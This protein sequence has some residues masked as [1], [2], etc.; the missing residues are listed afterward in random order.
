MIHFIFNKETPQYMY[1]KGDQTGDQNILTAF[2]QHCNLVDPI[3]YLPQWRGRPKFTQDFVFRY[4]QQSGGV[5]Y[6]CSIGLWQEAYI[7]FKKNNAEFTGLFENQDMIKTDV[8]ISLDDFK[9]TVDSWGLAFKPRDYQYA[10]SYKILQYRSSVSELA[11]RAGKTLIA[12]MVFRYAMERMNVRKILMIVPSIQLVK[13]AYNDFNEYKEFFKTECL[14]AGGSEVQSAN[15]TV[16]TFQSLIKYLD[17]KSKKFNPSFFDGYDC[18]FVDETH[19]ATAT[20]IKT[21]ISQP[22]IK[23]VKLKFGMTGTLPKNDTIPH[24]AL[25]ALLGAKIQQIK[26]AEL[27]E[28]GYISPVSIHQIRFHYSDEEC[29]KIFIK[30]GEYA[31]GNYITEKRNGKQCK[32]KLEQPENQIIYKKKLPYVLQE[33]KTAQSYTNDGYIELLRSIITESDSANL[34]VVERMMTHFMNGRIDYLCKNIL[35]NCP[36]NTLILAHHTEYI[37]KISKIISKKYPDRPVMVI[38]GS[39]TAKKRLEI[40][41]KLKER[42]DCILIASFGTMSTGITLPNLCHGI[43]F[44]SFKSNVVNMQSIGRGLGLSDMKDKYELYDCIDCFPTKKLYLQGLAKI[45]LYKENRYPF[46]IKDVNI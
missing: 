29:K 35:P 26:P 41:S 9:K 46:D 25:T 42:N 40:V 4:V 19:R 21:L 11:T 5:I 17:R 13:Q 38:T 31:V 43:L 32:M 6:Y 18:V 27:M 30:C 12:Y 33:Y 37:R 36:N 23:H 14:W 1:L 22:F 16:G 3:C 24:F 44:E 7:F 8:D 15:L 45:K 34:L 28:E 2:Q 39:V 10:A 20:Q